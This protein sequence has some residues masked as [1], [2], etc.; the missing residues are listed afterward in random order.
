MK[1]GFPAVCSPVLC[2]SPIWRSRMQIWLGS[3]S[4]PTRA[5]TWEKSGWVTLWG[6]TKWWGPSWCVLRYCCTPESWLDQPGGSVSKARSLPEVSAC[7][8][9]L[10]PVIEIGWIGR[11]V[12]G[13]CFRNTGM[14]GF[15]EGPWFVQGNKRVQIWAYF[16]QVQLFCG[17]LLLARMIS[18]SLGRPLVTVHCGLRRPLRWGLDSQKD[19]VRSKK[20]HCVLR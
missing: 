1:H 20:V 17:P 5:A 4:L 19:Q 14:M 13:K 15:E 8:P 10:S 2:T 18:Q 12:V 16:L 6:S 7:G 9:H 11:E 3:G